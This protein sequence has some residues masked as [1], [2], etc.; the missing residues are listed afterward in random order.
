MS[1]RL[2]VL[3]VA[4]GVLTAG[5]AFASG[6]PGASR[7]QVVARNL[8]NPR[9]VFVDPS[10]TVYVVLAGTGGNKGTTSCLTT[11]VGETGSIVKI[12]RGVAIPVLTGL[13]SQS[14]PGGR[15]AEGPAAALADG[16]TFLVLMQDMEI[17]SRG[18]N[19]VGLPHAGDLIAS[20]GGKVA[21]RVV[22]DL[23]AYEAV[24]NPDHGAG[25]GPSYAQPSI[26][27]DPY[28][29]VPFRGGYAVVD[30][31]G[32]DL[33]WVNPAGKVSLLAV[34]PPQP[35]RLSTADASIGRL[36]RRC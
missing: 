30:A 9:K 25:P 15:D 10:G 22:A 19:K 14:L 12:Q 6:S 7:L 31:A 26:D 5:A 16:S 18:V 8:D 34:F 1:G 24:H 36:P 27:S 33:L 13:G 21:A 3:G 4:L 28:G 11:C 32:N 23:A 29:F 35:I 17:D 20:P 2:A